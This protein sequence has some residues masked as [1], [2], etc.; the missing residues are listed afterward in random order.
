MYTCR[1]RIRA[2]IFAWAPI[3]HVYLVPTKERV[4]PKPSVDGVLAS[5]AVNDITVSVAI[6][7]VV[8]AWTHANHEDRMSKKRCSNKR[9]VIRQGQYLVQRYNRNP[10]FLE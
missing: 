2:Y 5:I 3:K 8:A 6:D 10:L 9:R 7:D 1:I 4:G